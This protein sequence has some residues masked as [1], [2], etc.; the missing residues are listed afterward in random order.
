VSSPMLWPLDDSAYA[1]AR[2][3]GGMVV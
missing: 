3:I 2:A 1:T